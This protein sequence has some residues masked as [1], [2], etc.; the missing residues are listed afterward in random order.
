MTMLSGGEKDFANHCTYTT[1]NYTK[2]NLPEDWRYTS[3]N[4]ENLID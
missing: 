1:D 2:H 3:S 4:Y